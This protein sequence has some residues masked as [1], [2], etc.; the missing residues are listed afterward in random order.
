MFESLEDRRLMSTSSFYNQ[1][2]LV[3]D[4]G[5]AGTRTDTTLVNAWG[6][7][8]SATG[9]WWVGSNEKGVSPAYDGSGASAAANVIIP[10]AA[11]DT[12]S[13][14]TGVVANNS[15]LLRR[16]QRRKQR[17]ERICLRY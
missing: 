13:N 8:H 1:T 15:R 3:S 7:D 14:P 10:P 11:G 5:V 9:P 6:L 2:N 4:N 12:E 16:Q 17:R